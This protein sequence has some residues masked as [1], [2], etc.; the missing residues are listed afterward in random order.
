MT[1]IAPSFYTPNDRMMPPTQQPQ[2][3]GLFGPMIGQ[4]TQSYAQEEVMP[5]FQNIMQDI[6]SKFP[7]AFDQMQPRQP[8][9]GRPIGGG[10]PSI[11]DYLKNN[12]VPQTNAVMPTT[13]AIQAQ[14][15]Q[16]FQQASQN[17][18]FDRMSNTFGGIGALLGTNT[19]M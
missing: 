4:I 18:S 10:F 2:G 5:Y 1:S 3:M 15:Q 12:G 8:G 6:Q 11:M 9:V 16:P 17:A 14:P 13:P 19:K 7:N